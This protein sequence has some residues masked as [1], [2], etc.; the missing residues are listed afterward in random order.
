VFRLILLYILIG[1]ICS[2]ASTPVHITHQYTN[3]N[4]QS[5]IGLPVGSHKTIVDKQGNLHWSH[6]NLQRRPLDSTFGFSD[7]MDGALVIEASLAENGTTRADFQVK[8]QS[9]FANRY[10]FVVT[11]RTAGDVRIEEVAFAAKAGE[12]ELDVIRLECTNSGSSKADIEIAL[13]GKW[14]NLPA[15]AVGDSLVTRNG[16]L[17]AI[18]Q[19]QGIAFTS[20]RNGLVLAGNWSIPA[21]LTLTLWLKLPYDSPAERKT[22]IADLDGPALLL[23]AQREWE[24]IWS[25][26]IRISLPQKE[27]EDFFYSSF[28]YVLILTERD[29]SGDLW[30]LDGPG[31]Y[32][33]FWGRGEYFQARALENLGSMDL[34]RDSVEHAF[35]IQMDDGE[36]DGPPIS[37]WPS[38]DNTGGNAGAVWDYYLVTRDREWLAKAYPH[39]LAAARWIRDHRE[40]SHYEDG[41]VPA[42]AKPIKRQIPWSC[43]P[44]REPPLAPGEKPYWFGLL[45]WSYGDSGLPEGHSF[46]HNYFGLYAVKCALHA[47]KELR[48]QEDEAW[49]SHEVED[50]RD[51][52]LS[53]IQHSLKLEKGEPQYLPA[54]PTYPDAA[55]SQSFAAVYPTEIFAPTD[56]LING[57]FTTMER[58][59][60]QGLPTNVAWLGPSGVWPGESMNIADVYVRRGEIAK[61]VAMLIAALNHSYFTNVWKEEIKVDNTLPVAC[62]NPQKKLDNGVGTGDM[63]EAWGN[64]NLVNLIRDMLLLESHATLEILPG[65]PA[66][67]INVGEKISVENAPTTF[68]GNV[69]LQLTY[70]TAHEMRLTIT[71]P[72]GSPDL[73][74][75]FPLAAGRKI[76]TARVDGQPVTASGEQT[77]TLHAVHG[78]V[79]IEVGF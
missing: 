3:S 78:T 21:G 71:A 46:P 7:Q 73:L 66:D 74:A 16:Y 37:G 35:H 2:A 22:H 8:D 19:G 49:L 13:S 29:A 33:Q 12:Q 1:S 40:E 70:P 56:P 27:I 36:W 20:K 76:S 28:A 43:R 51:A 60:R 63:P 44:E 79:R 69:S 32:R 30:I 72:P 54:M 67:W 24:Q 75:H 53:D 4:A 15:H 48:H 62:L 5:L 61:A 47:A 41:D 23:A 17:V 38:W 31:G 9:L 50:Y 57:L 10:P 68:G 25:Q 34:A 45:P 52:I 64:A 26:G 6:W 42:G 58:S 18:A 55:W 39:L 65:I 14:R 11:G 77:V 59:E